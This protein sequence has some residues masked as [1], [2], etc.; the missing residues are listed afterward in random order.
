M[1][2]ADEDG[3][4]AQSGPPGM[5]RFTDQLGLVERLRQ[6]WPDT[7]HHRDALH[8]EAADEIERL[9]A[10]LAQQIDYQRLIEDCYSRTKQAQGT[11]GCIQ[12]ARGAEWW[13]EQVQKA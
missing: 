12:F 1:T 7:P 5:V 9:R 4:T 13:R 3:K 6:Q 11:K 10:K 8:R 2:G